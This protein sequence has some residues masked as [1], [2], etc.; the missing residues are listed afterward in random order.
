MG[1]RTT[2]EWTNATW[3][4]VTGCT[5]VSPGCDHCYAERLTERF[6]W[7]PFSR[8]KLHFDR[9]KEPIGRRRPQLVFTCSMSD[10]FHPQVP[11]SFIIA[12]FSVMESTPQH[13]YQVLTK[14]PGRMAYFANH[15]LP[16]QGR[17]WPLNVWAGTSVESQRYAHR[18]TVL[19][20]VSAPVRFV[21]VEPLLESIDLRPW[22]RDG[23]LHWV[24][25]GGES[26]PGA[27]P[28]KLEW[29]LSIRDDCRSAGVPF[30]FKQWGG[31]TAK[32]GGRVLEGL[33]YD[34]MPEVRQPK[35]MGII[36]YT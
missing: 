13:I 14:R 21:S 1:Q 30:F 8:I 15:V 10:L 24:I 7:G 32:S 26:G 16:A 12:V 19:E 31:R 25:V 2:I 23:A 33:T 5:K 28:I 11:W 9:L 27:R 34:E 22:L 18:I 20:R 17:N 29:V 4:P 35:I 6:G 36:R 3:N